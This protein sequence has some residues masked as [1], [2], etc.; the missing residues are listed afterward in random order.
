MATRL[1]NTRI[2]ASPNKPKTFLAH[3]SGRCADSRTKL[4]RSENEGTHAARATP[5]RSAKESVASR[6]DWR[7]IGMAGVMAGLFVVG[8][9]VAVWA[10]NRTMSMSK[11]HLASSSPSPEGLAAVAKTLHENNGSLVSSANATTAKSNREEMDSLS[12]AS[13]PSQPAATY[14]EEDTRATAPAPESPLAVERPSQPES[15]CETAPAIKF[16]RDPMQ[17]TRLAREDHK[18]LFV[19]HVSGNFE[20]SKFT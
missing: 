2:M 6:I 18:L 8:S 5:A 4:A 12:V 7:I 13:G 3:A 17:A 11:W 10:A 9:V 1:R 20:E 15:D 19:L 14:P 16:A